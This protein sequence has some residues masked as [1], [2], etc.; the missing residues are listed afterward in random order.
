MNGRSTDDGI[1]ISGN[2][3]MQ[4]TAANAEHQQQHTFILFRR[5]SQA[6]QNK[7][8]G[9]FFFISPRQSGFQSMI[10]SDKNI[11]YRL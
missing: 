2:Q 1:F 10:I 3:L 11:F 6:Q 7:T 9:S 8:N 4:K 5:I